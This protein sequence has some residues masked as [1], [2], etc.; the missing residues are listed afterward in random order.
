MASLER[1]S[2]IRKEQL[3][4]LLNK[5]YAENKEWLKVYRKG[6]DFYNAKEKNVNR[7]KE[8]ALWF[9]VDLEEN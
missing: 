2:G 3:T 4:S 9:N 7:I 8:F 6:T 1:C 5:L